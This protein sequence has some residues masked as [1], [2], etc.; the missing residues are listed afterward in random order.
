MISPTLDAAVPNGFAFAF[1]LNAGEGA[2][3]LAILERRERIVLRGHV[4]EPFGSD[5]RHS[6]DEL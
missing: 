3:G 1:R 2:L 5:L 6:S 4:D